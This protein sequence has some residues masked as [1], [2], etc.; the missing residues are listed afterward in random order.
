MNDVARKRSRREEA[1]EEA[2]RAL[3]EEA[4]IA[5]GERWAAGWRDDLRQE[6]RPAAGGWPGTVAEARARVTAHLGPELHR[7]KMLALTHE[8]LERAARTAYARAR[9]DWLSRNEREIPEPA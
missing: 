5:T 2:R 4:S 1:T 9:R 8:E 7:R 3:L 6:G